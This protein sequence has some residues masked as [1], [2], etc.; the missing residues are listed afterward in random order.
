MGTHKY[1]PTTGGNELTFNVVRG[2]Y[3]PLLEMVVKNLKQAQEYASND[4]EKNMIAEYI[5]SFTE[6]SIEAHKNGSRHWIKDKGPI[7]ER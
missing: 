3:S 4:N 1:T 5:V 7:V 6:G 2:D